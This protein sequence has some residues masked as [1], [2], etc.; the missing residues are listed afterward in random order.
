M[1]AFPN[2]DEDPRRVREAV[3]SFVE[4]RRERPSHQPRGTRLDRPAPP[5]VG[6][7]GQL[8]EHPHGDPVGAGAGGVRGHPAGGPERAANVLDA[9]AEPGAILAAL[10]EAETLSMEG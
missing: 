6:G 10:E 9:D 2:A 1:F 5:G 7:G 4:A 8:L 3:R